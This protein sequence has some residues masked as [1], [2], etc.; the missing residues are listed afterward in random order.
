MN[1]CLAKDKLYVRKYVVPPIVAEGFT[2]PYMM[3]S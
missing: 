1:A 2:K 3:L